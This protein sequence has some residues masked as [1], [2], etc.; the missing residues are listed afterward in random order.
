VVVDTSELN[1]HE[2][3]RRMQGLF[4]AEAA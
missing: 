3:R 1:V 4:S 2:L